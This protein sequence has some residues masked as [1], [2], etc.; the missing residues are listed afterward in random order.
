V[1]FLFANRQRLEGMMNFLALFP[2]PLSVGGRAGNVWKD[3]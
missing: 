3:E 1:D 2:K